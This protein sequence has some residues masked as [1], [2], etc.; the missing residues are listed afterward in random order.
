[1]KIKLQ[2]NKQFEKDLKKLSV[3]QRSK[4][5]DRLRLFEIDQYNRLLR[6]HA[7][8]G[9]YLGYRSINISGDIRILYKL[10]DEDTALFVQIGTHSE[11]YG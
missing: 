8:N 6:N 11:L 7:L 5:G 2:F 4:M 9:K 10:I 1:M 3:K